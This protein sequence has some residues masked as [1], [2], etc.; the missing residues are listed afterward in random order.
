[1]SPFRSNFRFVFALLLA[2]LAFSARAAEL[3]AAFTAA[4]KQ[5]GIPLD[6]VAVVIQAVDAP[7]PRL[8]HNADAA[9]N[10]ASVMKLVTSWVALAQLGPAYTWTTEV[11]ANGVVRDGRLE[12]DLVIRGNGDPT[13]TLERIWLMQRELRAHG[14]R[15]IHG[16]LLLD[17]R[18][19]DLPPPD[20]GAFDG[21]PLASYNAAPG[22]LLANFNTLALRL[23]P[24]GGQVTVMPEIALPGVT[25]ESRLVPDDAPCNGWKD[26]IT[27]S[28]PDP[29]RHDLVLEGRYAR[30]CGEKILPLNLFEPAATFDLIFR[31]L[32]AEAGGVI[33][34]STVSGMAPDTPPLL[35]FASVPLADALTSLNKFSN[36][37]MTRNLFLTL[38]AQAER[39]PATL[40]K[41]QRAVRAA[42]AGQ[43]IDTRKLVLENGS[44]LS[45]IERVSAKLLT[46]LLLAAWRHPNFSEF[47]SALPILAIDGTLKNR[48]NGSP[49]AGQAH[50]KTGSLR[51]ARALAGYVLD[52]GGKRLA[53]VMLINH[54]N[55]EQAEPA[56]RIL[57]E[58]AQANGSAAP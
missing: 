45:R 1:M 26:R 20:P 28:I 5:A 36:N 37:V 53:F 22:P 4:L 9:M 35:R 30:A 44:G 13:L 21:E 50:L 38:G 55:A 52:A 24:V 17:S 58:W 54:A 25:F 40:E 46:Q 49:L 48:F 43:G 31:A 11:W 18:Y 19:F 12:G 41:G 32:W 56:Q 16:D 7:L 15:E 47:E 57:L 23:A 51:D 39:A 8:S 3:P 6:H 29:A 27:P 33:T 10:P 14:I 42:L 2:G 34:G